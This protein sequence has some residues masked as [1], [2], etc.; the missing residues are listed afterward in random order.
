MPKLYH[1]AE[2]WTVPGKQ[3]RDAVRVDVPSRPEELAQWLNDRCCPIDEGSAP[4]GDAPAPIEP[5]PITP[6]APSSSD[7]SLALDDAWDGLPLA[8]KLHFAA[9]A[10]EDARDAIKR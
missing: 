6:A 7:R 5:A 1:Q 3:D 8:R 10:L 9:L 4:I 2:G